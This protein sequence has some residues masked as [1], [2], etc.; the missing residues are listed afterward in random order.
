KAQEELRRTLKQVQADIVVASIG[1]RDELPDPMLIQQLKPRVLIIG[2]S[3]Y[4]NQD[5]AVERAEILRDTCVNVLD[6]QCSG[7]IRLKFRGGSCEIE[8]MN[9]LPLCIRR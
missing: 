2:N 7:A 5:R 9:G 6:T 8:P 4:S 1:E 3:R